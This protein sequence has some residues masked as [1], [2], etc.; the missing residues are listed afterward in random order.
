MEINFICFTAMFNLTPYC[1]CKPLKFHL[2][3]SSCRNTCRSLLKSS[4]SMRIQHKAGLVSNDVYDILTVKFF[5]FHPNPSGTV[6][7]LLTALCSSCRSGGSRW[8]CRRQT[9]G[10]EKYGTYMGFCPTQVGYICESSKGTDKL[11]FLHTQESSLWQKE[12]HSQPKEGGSA[13]SVAYINSGLL[14]L[15]AAKMCWIS[16]DFWRTARWLSAH[17]KKAGGRSV[18]AAQSQTNA[19]LVGEHHLLCWQKQ[20]SLPV[21]RQTHS[22]SSIK[23]I[24]ISLETLIL[25]C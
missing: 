15:A 25:L 20:V 23:Y 12:L 4:D 24:Y 8:L 19:W 13:Y 3:R 9:S 14:L 21:C 6:T 11:S 10:K 7:V 22:T 18:T 1:N 5:N 16:T 2:S 17:L